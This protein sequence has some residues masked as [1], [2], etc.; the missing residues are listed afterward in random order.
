MRSSD[1]IVSKQ[2]AEEITRSWRSDGKKVVFTN[3]CFDIIH[4]GHVDYLERSSKLANR[5]VVGVNTDLSVKILKGETRPVQ[6]ELA[7]SR[8]IAAFGFVDLVVLFG[9]ETPQ[10]LIEFLKPDVLVKGNDYAVADIAGSEFVIK[11][12]G[13]VETIE[14][15][16]A[17]S[18]SSIIEKIKN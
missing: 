14:L 15:V 12:G 4:L 8:I 10:S 1:K 13:K 5:L 11:N 3:G 7:R 2:K 6:N 17:Y 16:S 18:T 9:E